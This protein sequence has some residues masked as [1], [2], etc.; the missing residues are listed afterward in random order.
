[1]A[2]NAIFFDRDDTLIEDPGYIN[3]PDQVKLIA[4]VPEALIELKELGYKLI[5]VSNQSGVA[6]GMFTEEVLGQIH[7]RLKEL[8]A[9][10]GV[11][12]DQIYFCPYHPDGAIE[13]YRRD[14]DRRKPG[15]GM[16]LTAAD[17]MDIDLGQSWMIG[18]SDRD[19]IAGSRA[20]CKTILIYPSSQRKAIRHLKIKPD[21]EVVNMREAVNIIKKHLRSGNGKTQQQPPTAVTTETPAQSIEQTEQPVKTDTR[22]VDSQPQEPVESTQQLLSEILK[23]LNHMQRDQLFGEFSALRLMAGVLQ[24]IAA[25]CRIVSVSF[26]LRP[27]R[28]DSLVFTTLGFGILIQMMALTFYLIDRRK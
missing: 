28:T 18:N 8:L 15:P 25:A 27:N 16:L 26:V 20:G 24:I 19:I 5:V 4:G 11:F 17:E 12:L 2:D 6:H 1:M 3:H 22:Q 23:Q 9:E 7:D 14:S 21:H 13:K 10:K